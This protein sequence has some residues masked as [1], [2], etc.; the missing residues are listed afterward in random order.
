MNNLSGTAGKLQAESQR[1]LKRHWPV[2]VIVGAVLL[3]YGRAAGFEFLAWDDETYLLGNPFLRGFSLGNLRGILTPGRI[4]GERLYIPLTYFSFLLESA[5]FG[6]RPG[7]GHGLNVLLHALNGVLAYYFIRA[8]CRRR[9][10]ALFAAL[11]FALHPLQVESVA[12][13]ISRKELLSAA[14]ALF[15]LLL[16]QRFRIQKP[17]NR[18]T[19]EP[20]NRRTAVG[21]AGLRRWYYLA[22]AAFVL[23]MLAKP[24]SLI[25]PALLVL[26]DYYHNGRATARD[27]LLKVP[28][29]LLAL[30]F[31]LINTAA[32]TAP[33]LVWQA[34]L[35]QLAYLP[36]V[37]GGWLA[38]LFL[39]AKPNPQYLTTAL[40]PGALGVLAWLPVFALLLLLYVGLRAKVRTLWF[41]LLFAAVAFAPALS[42]LISWN[43]EF[44]TADR[45]GYFPMLGFVL[46]IAAGLFQATELSIP[47]KPRLRQTYIVCMAAAA[48]LFGLASFRLTGVWR[49]TGTFCEYALRRN[50]RNHLAL[51]FLGTWHFRHGQPG[52]AAAY[53]HAARGAR[54]S[55]VRAWYNLGVV[56]HKAQPPRLAPAAKFYRRALVVDP[57]FREAKHG[58]ARIAFRRGMDYDRKK[59]YEKALEAFRRAVELDPSRGAGWYNIGW[60][61]MQRNK[62]QAAREPFQKAVELLPRDADSRFQLGLSYLSCGRPRRAIAHIEKALMLNPK[63]LAGH[64]ALAR[65]YLRVGDYQRAIVHCDRAASQGFK[66]D[67]ELVNRLE[68]HRKKARQH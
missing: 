65:A 64:E 3:V 60:L 39:I 32:D 18:T 4:P 1:C 55:H 36:H 27:W 45:Y 40:A 46:I 58:L 30:I 16:Y 47:V 9:I 57:H 67:P 44:Y 63:L 66:I 51:T 37:L 42:I 56:H 53:Y 62:P 17:R 35:L 23:S 68:P 41:G 52:V 13:V 19:G 6:L 7:I 12:W 54:H 5:V 43:R 15:T 31:Y 28:F 38:R 24:T 2:L 10:P 8:L 22:L 14:F 29:A 26:L 59:N 50:P 25:L 49:N 61:Y 48:L 20:E 21:S 11:L 34:K 33:G